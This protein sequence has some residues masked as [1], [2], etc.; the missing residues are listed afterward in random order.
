MSDLALRV[1]AENK[2]TRDTFLDLG[3]CGLVRIAPE[4]QE[5][6]WLE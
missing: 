3:N 5:L 6:V 4:I 2:K 1:V